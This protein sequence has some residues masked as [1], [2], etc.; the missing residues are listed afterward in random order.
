[1][2][3]RPSSKEVARALM[4]LRHDANFQTLT[5]HIEF[6]RARACDDGMRTHD[7]DTW[8]QC[9]GEYLALDALLDRIHRPEKHA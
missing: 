7:A 4:A 1:M 5:R 6:E 8:R 2:S 3:E 9:R